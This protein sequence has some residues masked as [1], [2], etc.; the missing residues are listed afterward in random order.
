MRSTQLRAGA[1]TQ[2]DIDLL[3]ITDDPDEVYEII[4]AYVSASH[5]ED[6]IKDEIR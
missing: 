3:K 2:A 5:P 1:V 6:V 4:R